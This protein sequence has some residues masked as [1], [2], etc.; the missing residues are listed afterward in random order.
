MTPTNQG[1]RDR[2]FQRKRGVIV[3]RPY[4]IYSL[5]D[6]KRHA[7]LTG[8]ISLVNYIEKSRDRTL[9]NV[10]NLGALNDGTDLPEWSRCPAP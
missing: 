5:M 4:R 9:S 2:L 10:D 6:K 3:L 7:V 8:A 1:E